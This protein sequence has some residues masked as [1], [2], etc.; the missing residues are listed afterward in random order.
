MCVTSP[1]PPTS[2]FTDNRKDGQIVYSKVTRIALLLVL[3]CS[4]DIYG[5]IHALYTRVS[6]RCVNMC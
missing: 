1:T 2:T 3:N 6:T 5:C 4:S